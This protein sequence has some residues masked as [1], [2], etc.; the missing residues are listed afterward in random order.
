MV[1]DLCVSGCHWASMTSLPHTHA[2]IPA[3]PANGVPYTW[4]HFQ[5]QGWS[6]GN[7]HWSYC[8]RELCCT[9]DSVGVHCSW[10]L[11]SESSPKA[12]TLANAPISRAQPCF[13]SHGARASAPRDESNR[14]SRERRA[15]GFPS[16][17]SLTCWPIDF[18]LN[19]CWPWGTLKWFQHLAQYCHNCSAY[20]KLRGKTHIYTLHGSFHMT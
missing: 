13:L 2:W 11:R 9:A 7:K 6:V 20:Y 15:Q 10:S 18:I 19:T 4:A 8:R 1:T 17:F 5:K 16:F 14:S 3:R 12:K